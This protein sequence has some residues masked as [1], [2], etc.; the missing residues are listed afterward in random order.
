MKMLWNN[1]INEDE[2]NNKINM[3]LGSINFL[4][5]NKI[6]INKNITL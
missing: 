1:L 5:I 2:W 4:Y 6:E 3:L